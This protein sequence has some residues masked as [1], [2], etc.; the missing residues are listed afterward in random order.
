MSVEVEIMVSNI[1]KAEMLAAPVVSSAVVP[2]RAAI[3]V[4]A[5]TRAD[6]LH[7]PF[8]GSAM[9]LLR[10]ADA[11]ITQAVEA[12]DVFDTFSHAHYAA[13]RLAG[14][15]VEARV[16]GKRARKT[17]GFWEKLARVEPAFSAW[18]VVFEEAAAVRSAVEAG[19]A[20]LLDAQEA[21]YW[22]SQ[23]RSFRIEVLHAFSLDPARDL[24]SIAHLAA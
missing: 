5:S 1:S 11:Q 4:R 23:V 20:D 7:I 8:T 3:Q 22:L 16:R 15:V 21:A 12:R 18:S 2:A 14:A 10:S 24:N 17:E 9:R 13:L 19:R 6:A